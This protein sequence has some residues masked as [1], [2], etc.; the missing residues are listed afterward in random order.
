MACGSSSARSPLA[1]GPFRG[2]WH[3]LSNF[4]PSPV[5]LDGVEYPTVEHA[6]H[7]A[8]CVDERDR[9]LI[10]EARSPGEAK[11]LGRRVRQLSDWEARR[12]VVM[13]SLLRQKFRD[14]V[15]RRQLLFTGTRPL[16]EENDWG[17]TYWGIHD[18]RGL[19]RLGELL[20]VV[21]DEVKRDTESD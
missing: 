4:Y 20:K 17:D 12:D 10:I 11:R 21:R 6:Y 16:V 14:P 8:R 13:L 1:I 18:G 9:M 5:T 2:R 7:A 3:F 15:L 19:N